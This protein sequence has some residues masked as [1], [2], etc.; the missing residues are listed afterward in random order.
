MG[1]T[2][3]GVAGFLSAGLATDAEPEKSPG[4]RTDPGPPF[5]VI[6]LAKGVGAAP[7]DAGEC[8]IESAARTEP[9]GRMAGRCPLA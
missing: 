8:A 3:L 1:G 7:T 4:V 6:T 2:D 9:G 5:G